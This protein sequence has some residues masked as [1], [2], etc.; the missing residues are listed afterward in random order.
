[1]VFRLE[2]KRCH[3]VSSQKWRTGTNRIRTSGGGWSLSGEGR[4]IY[5][6]RTWCIP[7]AAV[8]VSV[9]VHQY[10]EVM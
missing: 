8:T 1:M 5:D 7:A 9:R 4:A 2:G 10:G 6:T 3:S